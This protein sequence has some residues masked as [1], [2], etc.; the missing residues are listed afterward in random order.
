MSEPS[1][2]F[3][4]SFTEPQAH[5]AEINMD[6]TGFSGNTLDLALPVWTPGSYLIREYERHIECMEAFTNEDRIPF[7]KVSKNIWR[8]QNPPNQL[9]IQYRVYGFETSVRTNMIN[10]DRAFISPAATFLYIKNY[11][12]I[13]A[14]VEIKLP[15]KWQYISTGLPRVSSTEPNTFYAQDFD[16]LYDS[17]FEIGNQDI[18]HFEA[19]GVQ[20][21][22]A[23]VG[24]GNYDKE[25]LTNDI[26]KIV[27]QETAI[28]EENPNSRYV[29]ITH[30]YQTGGG[31]LE[32]LNS[33]VLGASRNA[34]QTPVAYKNFLCLVAHEYFHLWNVKRL[35][36]KELGPFRY[37]EEN[38]TT[39]LWMMEGFTSY[40]DNLIIRRCGFFTASEYLDMLAND[41]NQVYNRPGHRIQSAGL[42]SFDA[43]IK[44]YR[45]DENSSNTSISYYNKGAMLAVALDLCILIET[46]GEKRLDDVLRA[47]YNVF[48]KK[49]N[50]GFN[51]NEFH[52]LA[53]EVTG[54][55]LTR[56]FEAAHHTEELDYNSFF[57]R[58]GYELIDLNLGRK[59]LSLGIK[60]AIQDGRIIIKNVERGSAGWDAG[61]NVEDE[62]IAVNGNRLDTLG[63]ELE[64]ILQNGNEHDIVD[65]L[66]SRDGLLRTIHTPLRVSSKQAWSIRKKIDASPSEVELGKIWLSA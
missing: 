4:V 34:Y 49:E 46:K 2:H 40:Y 62:L 35:R 50:R 44:H 66:I 7:K 58:V 42:A 24:G 45:P 13:A 16:I 5:Y 61:L 41:F 57:H 48:Y 55:N 29:F 15:E 59:D 47:A 38:Y 22:F 52:E 20:H 9:K 36:P 19:A 25:Q 65:I 10:I 43:W 63:K 54:I 51:E 64:F 6:I 23:M 53:E 30:N 60:I 1:I 11:I 14:Q 3:T 33:T 18:W 27:E 8:I 39:G 17:P 32:H 31:G 12:D 26:T 37:D 56:I 21:E 28:W